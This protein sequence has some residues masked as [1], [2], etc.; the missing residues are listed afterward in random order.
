[1]IQFSLVG[2][3]VDKVSHGVDSLCDMKCEKKIMD[4][5][6]VFAIIHQMT[7][8][9]HAQRTCVCK[10]PSNDFRSFSIFDETKIESTYRLSPRYYELGQ[11]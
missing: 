3:G 11:L 4:G 1:M 2:E 7:K 8:K 5:I 10:Y 6:H 9:N